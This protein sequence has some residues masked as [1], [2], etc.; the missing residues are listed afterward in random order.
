MYEQALAD[1]VGEEKFQILEEPVVVVSN[2]NEMNIQTVTEAQISELK[3]RLKKIGNRRAMAIASRLSSGG[4]I[5]DRRLKETEKHST[6]IDIEI[7]RIEN[8]SARSTAIS[9]TSTKNGVGK[10]NNKIDPKLQADLH[11]ATSMLVD[12]GMIT[13]PIN[14]L[15]E[16]LK[17]MKIEAKA[18]VS[19]IDTI[20]YKC[21]CTYS[22]SVIT[23]YL[24]STVLLF[25]Y[26]TL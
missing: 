16:L 22:C 2:P 25:C 3:N 23:D 13:Y 12:N 8:I 15:K 1:V 18:D 6:K 17:E 19:L 4:D 26:I 7:K 21:I 5:Q 14:E 10:K 20:I 9:N 11:N 24:F